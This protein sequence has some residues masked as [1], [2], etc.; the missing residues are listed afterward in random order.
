[1]DLSPLPIRR[2]ANAVLDSLMNDFFNNNSSE[3]Q[4]FD[5]SAFVSKATES[6]SLESLRSATALKLEDTRAELVSSINRDYEA[7]VRLSSALEETDVAVLELRPPVAKAEL[8]YKEL[9][10]ALLQRNA[11][12]ETRTLKK[13]IALCAETAINGLL[14]AREFYKEAEKDVERG[15]KFLQFFTTSITS[16]VI[17]TSTNSIKSMSSLSINNDIDTL[18]KTLLYKTDD[19]NSVDTLSN[20]ETLIKI[21]SLDEDD[22][23]PTSSSSSS[24]HYHH[25]S[26][27]K[28]KENLYESLD[29]ASKHLL[30]ASSRIAKACEFLI[31][32]NRLAISAR[33]L[34]V[35]KE[36]SSSQQ[37]LIIEQ[38]H[39]SALSRTLK[40]FILSRLIPL[41]KELTTTC[42][43]A[44]LLSPSTTS[45]SS[46]ISSKVSISLH[47]CLLSASLLGEDGF[48][49]IEESITASYTNPLLDSLLSQT[50]LDEGGGRGSFK[51]V[52]KAFKALETEISNTQTQN[53]SSS[54]IPFLNILINASEGV[55]GL[56]IISRCFWAPIVSRL[57]AL[58]AFFSPAIP[59]TFHSNFTSCQ[60]L[61]KVIRQA[62]IHLKVEPSICEI[63]LQNDIGNMIE[64]CHDELCEERLIE[65]VER[66]RLFKGLGDLIL[67]LDSVVDVD[68][69]LV[70]DLSS[71]KSIHS[72]S[73]IFKNA[74]EALSAHIS[75]SS[76]AALW[77][78]KMILYSQI[79]SAELSQRIE[80][81]LKSPGAR[82]IL[83]SLP[84][85]SLS[86]LG[87]LSSSNSSLPLVTDW[88]LEKVSRLIDVISPLHSVPSSINGGRHTLRLASSA[89]TW[90]ALTSVWSPTVFLDAILGATILQSLQVLNRYTGWL[91]CGAAILAQRSGN[92]ELVT[93][94]SSSSSSVDVS[95]LSASLTSS[96]NSMIDLPNLSTVITR[97]ISQQSVVSALVSSQSS[98]S[99]ASTS[100]SASLLYADL[101]L[102]AESFAIVS[103]T[104]ALLQQQQLTHVTGIE[105]L[106]TAARDALIISDCAMHL[107]CSRALNIAKVPTNITIQ[108]LLDIEKSSD[109]SITM[110]LSIIQSVTGSTASLRSIV[111]YILASIHSALLKQ[112][113]A[114]CQM[115]KG[116]P[117]TLRMSTT[118][119]QTSTRT[120]SPY[121]VSLLRPLIQL[122]SSGG[123]VTS[124]LNSSLDP[125]SS[126]LPRFVTGVVTSIVSDYAASV[127]SVL[128]SLQK[129]E[130]SLQW[131]KT[132]SSTLASSSSSNTTSSTISST[133]T[134]MA[135]TDASTVGTQLAIDINSLGKTIADAPL[136]LF[137][138]LQ[139]DIKANKG[140][141][142]LSPLG[143]EEESEEARSVRSQF[144]RL[145]L[146]VRPFIT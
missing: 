103:P 10:E 17:N 93:R 140:V 146:L 43:R 91:A 97:L 20:L 12:I 92:A 69:T 46:S 106:F 102:W 117:A 64:N 30:T 51:G 122:L 15:T 90:V 105:A 45:S 23:P 74:A 89:N 42:V 135:T 79:R 78:P 131:L 58:P 71:S 119:T 47:A 28:S 72:L 104:G 94:L 115:V 145:E 61:F 27:S 138:G 32:S 16:D 62:C 54:S 11:S 121:V 70:N 68:S 75:T 87:D 139:W 112:N 34:N 9:S 40:S 26:V 144:L 5:L 133:S 44:V 7:F 99:N 132:S 4:E 128:E 100:T 33:T 65:V 136:G 98:T 60:A 67:A 55:P 8:A 38:R 25:Q 137:L 41:I 24:N 127:S 143:N 6:L 81:A 2:S 59:S 111:P 1:M 48:K 66:K 13:R 126:Y 101:S 57:V 85:S 52:G 118:S 88:T 19:V 84:L 36:Y 3:N 107:I 14:C 73:K 125:L 21:V 116:V 37:I 86:I 35:D 124:S 82:L 129:T 109:P 113:A 53:T 63:D 110:A 77:R 108:T 29:T 141:G 130:A 120:A 22:Q 96:T 80:S 39:F 76:L 18:A 134:T 142:S 56:E 83:Q 50:R 114:V 95:S 31:A 123:V 49:A